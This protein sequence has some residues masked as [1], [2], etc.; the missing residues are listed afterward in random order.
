MW[1]A[2]EP[3]VY[4]E[5]STHFY[6]CVGGLFGKQFD[7]WLNVLEKNTKTKNYEDVDRENKFG[8]V[9]VEDNEEN[10]ASFFSS[11]NRH[12]HSG[13][14]PLKN[15]V[16][17]CGNEVEPELPY[18]VVGVGFQRE[19]LIVACL[20]SNNNIGF[21]KLKSN[22]KNVDEW[23]LVGTIYNKDYLFLNHL[24][25]SKD[26]TK[27]VTIATKL[28]EYE[29]TPFDKADINIPYLCEISL[30]Y[31]GQATH[32]INESKTTIEH[33]YIAPLTI[34]FVVKAPFAAEYINNEIK[35][36]D[37]EIEFI[38][39]DYGRDLYF[40]P[41][42]GIPY[43][44]ANYYYAY[45]NCE[46]GEHWK[47][48]N[49][50]WWQAGFSSCPGLAI[51]QYQT[52]AS[53]DIKVSSGNVLSYKISFNGFGNNKAI[54]TTKG[55]RVD[56]SL[57]YSTLGNPGYPDAPFFGPLAKV[58]L[59]A[60]V[61]RIPDFLDGLFSGKRFGVTTYFL[62]G[63]VYSIYDT[64]DS[65]KTYSFNIQDYTTRFVFYEGGGFYSNNQA[66]IPAQGTLLDT[67]NDTFEGRESGLGTGVSKRD[68]L[69]LVDLSQELF[70]IGGKFGIKVI[71]SGKVIK[72]L[73]DNLEVGRGEMFFGNQ[74][75]GERDGIWGNIGVK[76]SSKNSD[77]LLQIGNN[78]AVFNGNDI[79]FKF[80]QIGVS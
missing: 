80:E 21:F 20:I 28:K 62:A 78:N 61:P 53:N 67:L 34:K 49:L 32:Q 68:V 71:K 17:Q 2:K 72:E 16:Y 79:D 76:Y 10:S 77:Y 5:I 54:Y 55:L 69:L 27:A 60:I 3:S 45:W 7:K 37:L 57:S 1:S 29:R 26:G 38:A 46:N 25:F 31:S 19:E 44:T 42:E 59:H 24:Y 56:S 6:P 18:P 66:T 50:Y 75:D 35:T 9:Y 47:V 11:D 65:L 39:G 63:N 13:I 40:P 14:Y 33:S 64:G 8:T 12:F 70:V 4:P 73:N 58:N 74:F 52:T 48:P 43:W 41:I 22:D 30:S 51:E 23:L 15:K 36:F